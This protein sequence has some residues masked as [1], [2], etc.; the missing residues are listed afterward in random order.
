V[1]VATIRPG[2]NPNRFCSSLSVADAPNVSIPMTR[3][4]SC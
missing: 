2:S 3:P 4:E 1:A